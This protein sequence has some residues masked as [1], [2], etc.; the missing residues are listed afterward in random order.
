MLNSHT[1]VAQNE[2]EDHLGGFTLTD[3][4]SIIAVSLWSPSL[5]IGYN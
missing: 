3:S 5:G 1:H 2:N 4:L